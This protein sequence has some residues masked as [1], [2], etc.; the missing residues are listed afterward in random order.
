[1]KPPASSTTANVTVITRASVRARRLLAGCSGAI[2]PPRWQRGRRYRQC[3]PGGNKTVGTGSGSS[4]VRA[5]KALLPT[6]PREVEDCAMGG[7]SVKAEVAPGATGGVK[8]LAALLLL[9][10][11]IL[12]FGGLG[13]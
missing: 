4:G 13:L 12:F 5:V 11:L 1:M 9:L 8:M 2:L 10:L 3:M 6:V 7:G